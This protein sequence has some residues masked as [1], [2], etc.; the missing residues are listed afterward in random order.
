MYDAINRGWAR[1]HGDVLSWLN[2]D[3]QYLPGAL[4]AVSD[5][6]QCHPDVDIVFGDAL[7][8]DPSGGLI[9][10]RREIPL[11]RAY[12]VGTFLYSLSCATFFRRSLLDA[13]E[14]VFDVDR[15]VVGDAELLLSLLRR[16]RRAFHLPRYVGL[17]TIDGTNLSLDPVARAE[18]NEVRGRGGGLVPTALASAARRVEKAARGCYRRVP[19]SYDWAEDELPTYRRFTYPRAPTRF[20]WSTATA[21]APSSAG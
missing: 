20:D 1:S 6:F 14:L 16:G 11:R 7:I 8:V 4:A 12:V 2:A 9:A 5:A 3:E 18:F 17:F 21:A 13:G 15:K 19:V 10:A